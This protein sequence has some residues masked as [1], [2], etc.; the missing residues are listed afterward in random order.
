MMKCKSGVMP[1]AMM[2]ALMLM[3]VIAGCSTQDHKGVTDT[4]QPKRAAVSAADIGNPVIWGGA[5]NVVSVKHLYF[6]DQPDA[7]TLIEARDRG[8]GTVINL[9]DPSEFDWDEA[10][11]AK[12]AGLAYYN[13]PIASDSTSFDIDAMNQISALVKKHSDQKILLHCASGNRASAWLAIH[14]VKDHGMNMDSSILLAQKAGLT[15]PAIE[16]R[17]REFLHDAEQSSTESN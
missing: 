13:I 5:G 11:A 6:S 7:A 10:S 8:V 16:A 17:V 3:S 12:D 9:R 2:L 15:K 14:L 4:A 1:F